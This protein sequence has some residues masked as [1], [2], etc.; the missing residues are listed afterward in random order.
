MNAPFSTKLLSYLRDRHHREGGFTL[1][2]VLVVVII[3]GILASISYP[4][5]LGQVNKAKQ[6]EAKLNIGAIVR[7][8]QIYYLEQGSFATDL[9]SLA[10]GIRMETKRYRY[11][12]ATKDNGQSIVNGALPKDSSLRAYLG[13]AG[14]G[15]SAQGEIMIVTAICESNKPMVLTD[16]DLQSLAPNGGGTEIDCTR[17]D[18]SAYKGGFRDLR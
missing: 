4:S 17:P 13:F 14:I 15:F 11:D 5:M 1:I 12:M 6:A 18:L 3:I 9:P 16:S 10:M 2:E 7:G 8:Q